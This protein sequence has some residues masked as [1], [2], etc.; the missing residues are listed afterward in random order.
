[1]SFNPNIPVITDPILQSSAQIRANFRAINSAFADNHVGL[2][3]NEL[4]SG[5]HSVLSMRTVTDPATSATQTAIYNKLVST[6]PNLFYRPSSN[7]TPIQMTYPSIKADSSNTQYS[8]IAGP[9]IIY[10]GLLTNITSGQVVNLSPGTALISVD[11]ILTNAK[12]PVG[13]TSF[14][15]AAAEISGNSF[16]IRTLPFPLT[17]TVDAYYFAVGQ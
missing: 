16:T 13:G 17:A 12:F 6:I 1:L 7:Q 11:V 9:F 3:Q 2:T 15:V 10:G 5:M 14:L 8:F 4:F